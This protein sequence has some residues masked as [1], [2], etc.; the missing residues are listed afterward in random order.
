MY[1]CLN[2]NSAKDN[3]H[4]LYI[5]IVFL[6]PKIF[7]VRNMRSKIEFIFWNKTCRDWMKCGMHKWIK[8]ENQLKHRTVI[9]STCAQRGKYKGKC[10]SRRMVASFVITITCEDKP[11][12]MELPFSDSI[13]RN[14]FLIC[15]VASFLCF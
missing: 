10:L 8:D 6:I 5:S 1:N 7:P 15:S 9:S 11:W 14:S 13:L 4:S 2:I 3:I 12:F